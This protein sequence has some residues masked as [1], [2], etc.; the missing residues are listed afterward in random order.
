MFITDAKLGG[1]NLTEWDVEAGFAH[2]V[3][4][5]LNMLKT[6]FADSDYKET[7]RRYRCETLSIDHHDHSVSS[8]AE[9]LCR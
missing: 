9:Q 6:L 8:F 2:F 1:N 7:A 4:R 3:N 5:E